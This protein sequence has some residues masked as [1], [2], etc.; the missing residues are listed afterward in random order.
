MA[1][2]VA[3]EQEQPAD[4]NLIPLDFSIGPKV[5]AAFLHSSVFY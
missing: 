1:V 5:M 2:A 3:S 4:H